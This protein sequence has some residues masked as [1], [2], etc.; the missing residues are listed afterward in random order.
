LVGAALFYLALAVYPAYTM[1][2]VVATLI[3]GGIYLGFLERTETGTGSFRYVKWATGTVTL[4][5]GGL[6]MQNLMK[7]SIDW[8]PYSAERLEQ[9]RIEGRPVMIDFNADWCIPCLE[10][11]RVTFTDPDVIDAT[12]DFVRLKV[13]MTQ[14]E[15]EENRQLREEFQIAGV[16]TIVFIDRDGN[17]VPDTRVVGFLQPDRFLE[18][19]EMTRSREELA[20][21]AGHSSHVRLLRMPVSQLFSAP[22]SIHVRIA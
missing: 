7:E 16:P 19:I 4:L 18:R 21:E 10:L 2:V 6:L 3:I 17:E 8:E 12:A 13:D 20:A 5:I 9:A 15:S 11:E 14:Y 1:H 22:S